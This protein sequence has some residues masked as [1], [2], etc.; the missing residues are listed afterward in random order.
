MPLPLSS[1]SE[2]V[3]AILAGLDRH[4]FQLVRTTPAHGAEQGA[5]DTASAGDLFPDARC[6]EEALSGLFLRLGDWERSHQ[7]SQELVTAEG[8]YWHG[9]AHRLEPDYGNAG[10]WFRRVEKHAIFPP[11]QA[12]A[13]AILAEH[14]VPWRLKE[15]WDPLL[16]IRWC[17]EAVA[18]G[19]KEQLTAAAAIQNAE[20]ELLFEWCG[21]RI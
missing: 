2:P 20:W 18:G 13:S 21:A 4:P 1:F 17:E 12:A 6:P 11:L 5:L 16:F 14:R 9:I 10:Y 19:N 3:R 7:L 15:R 8:S